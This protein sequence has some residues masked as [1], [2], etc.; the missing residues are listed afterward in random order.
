MQLPKIIGFVD[1]DDPQPASETLYCECCG[2]EC[3]SSFGDTRLEVTYGNNTSH[4][5][6]DC[7]HDLTSRVD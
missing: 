2:C 1:L 5:C 3:D 4:V 6:L 7:C